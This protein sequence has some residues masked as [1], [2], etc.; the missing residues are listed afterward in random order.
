MPLRIHIIDSD[1]SVVEQLQR[2]LETEGFEVLTAV[3]GQAGLAMAELN[4]PSLIL[5]DTN[6]PD[7]HGHEICRALRS[8]P[9]T[10]D[11]PILIYSARAKVADKVAGFNAGA[12]DYIVK[13]VAA[14]ELLARINAALRTEQPPL[15]HIVALWGT[16]GGVG[17]TTLA[18]NLAVALRSKT[19][20]RVTLMDASI[21]GGTLDVLLN[22]P[23][24]H[25]I[26]D[27]LPRLDDLDSELLSSVLAIHSSGVKALLSAP[28]NRDG[29]PVQPTQLERILAWL[30]P[31][32]DYIVVDTSPSLDESTLT[33]LQLS[34][35]V[36]VVLTPEMTSLRNAK[37][38]LNMAATL[39]DQSQKQI[40]A[41]NRYPSRGGIKLK[42]IE[43]ALRTK[44]DVQI[45]ADEA[46][47]T[48][49][50]NRGIPLVS[51]DPRSPVAT[52]LSRLAE[53]VMAAAKEDKPVSILSTVLRRRA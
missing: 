47:V 42:D 6:L 13:P 3:T 5:M 20:K 31:A 33:V 45:P 9:S 24:R 35:Q 32:S 52:G 17:T 25:T 40:L 29:T 39:Q 1:L 10:A 36:I 27:L 23:P 48:Y 51:S 53:K 18:T 19:R 15:A 14:A 49:S 41:L 11:T 8:S 46:L 37:L 50:I 44:V 22:L 12:N 30:Q 7:I 16:K 38:F 21:L 43:A 26:A 4:H 34:N 28:W 2:I